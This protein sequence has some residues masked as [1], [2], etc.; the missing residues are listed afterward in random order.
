MAKEMSETAKKLKRATGTKFS[1]RRCIEAAEII[2]TVLGP[3][4]D[5][6]E[7]LPWDIIRRALRGKELKKFVRAARLEIL[8][9]SL[10]E[11]LEIVNHLWE[12]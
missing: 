12:D 1:Q 3:R 7:K 4:D 11:A 8:R 9:R 2:D 6:E 5:P 10:N